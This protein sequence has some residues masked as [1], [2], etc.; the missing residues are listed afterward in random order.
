MLVGDSFEMI[1]L[2]LLSM[3]SVL[4]AAGGPLAS[5]LDVNEIREATS[6]INTLSE[7]E[8]SIIQTWLI[9]EGLC[10]LAYYFLVFTAV[11]LLGRRIIQAMIAGYRE[12]KAQSV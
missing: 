10:R 9:F 12:A 4:S 5:L 3:I 7:D 1:Y 6:Y 8:K 2:P 11:F